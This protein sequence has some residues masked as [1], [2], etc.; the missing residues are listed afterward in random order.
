MKSNK[1]K[2]HYQ[3]LDMLVFYGTVTITGA[4][5]MMVEL[6]GTR[7]IGPYYGVSLVVWSSL[8]SVSLLA[9]SIGYFIGGHCA[10]KN[11]AFRLPHAVF[12][13]GVM[14]ALIPPLSQPV[15][16]FFN[17]LGL[18]GGALSSAFVLFTPALVFLG[19]AGPFVIRTATE[20]LENVGSTAG[21]VYAIS[22]IGSVAG[23][24][25]LGFFLLPLFGTYA[26]LISLA[27]VLIALALSLAI[28]EKNR[29][30]V[31]YKWGGWIVSSA[32]VLGIIGLQLVNNHQKKALEDGYKVVYEA[33]THYGWVRVIDQEDKELRW[34]M[35]D[36]STIG[37][38][39]KPTG[40][41]LLG[42]QT[43][44][45]NLPLFNSEGK[46]ALLIGLGAGHL[47]ADLQKYGI[48]TDAIEIDPAVAFAAEHYFNL[49]PTGKV[50]VGDARYQ[51]QQLNKT[52]DFI[53]HDCFTGGAEP[54]HL[55][56]QEMMQELKT[57]LNP[58]GILAINFVGFT[59]KNRLK[60]VKAIAATLDA[61]FANRKNYARA[62]EQE[63][64]D[65]VFIVSDSKLALNKT[66]ASVE[67]ITW[68][69]EHELD[70]SGDEVRIITDD[71]NPL[72]YL[73]IAK[74]E[75]YRDVLVDRV[76]ASVL[77]R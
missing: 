46:T 63:F 55:L 72:E 71:Y 22:T 27:F 38:E 41:G 14:V 47:V 66:S 56:S 51:V 13:A 40:T 34:L 28:Y 74:A 43:I 73:Q 36:A 44:V 1:Q 76:G 58:G 53:I 12:A 35:S 8:L 45:R 64:S 17:V 25:L 75:Y 3:T 4:A 23:T 10:D 54:F 24:L 50:I 59:D 16:V 21:N 37:V 7:I 2:P 52:Y 30:G 11:I 65:Y 67:R 68:L 9:L 15:Q 49:K 69:N 42:Y 33:E 70:I 20:R 32:I 48:K 61:E 18:R 6:L 57:K 26:I 5:V 62:P 19:M 60:P 39:H 77:F 29:L 31:K